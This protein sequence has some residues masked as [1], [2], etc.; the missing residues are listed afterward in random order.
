MSVRGNAG[1]FVIA[2]RRQSGE[3]A[4]LAR[5]PQSDEY[6]VNLADCAAYALAKTMHAPLLFEGMDFTQTDI[7]SAV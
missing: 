6:A 7:N 5:D 1:P 3:A 4:A 2:A